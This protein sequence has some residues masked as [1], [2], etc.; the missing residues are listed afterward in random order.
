MCPIICSI[1]L[2]TN[3]VNRALTH[4]CSQ[5]SRWI[6]YQFKLGWGVIR[7]RSCNRRSWIIYKRT[8]LARRQTLRT[9]KL[10]KRDPTSHQLWGHRTTQLTLKE[11]NS[12]FLQTFTLASQTQS[13]SLTLKAYPMIRC[14]RTCFKRLVVFAFN[15]KA[16]CL[17]NRGG[18][19]SRSQCT[20]ERLIFCNVIY[21]KLRSSTPF[22]LEAEISNHRILASR[23][24]V[25]NRFT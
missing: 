15:L 8:T 1:S 18:L 5:P 25:P 11:W 13:T 14:I 6:T 22:H 16:I 24:R 19:T 3:L 21:L 9:R 7:S 4:W 20:Q 23:I 17:A 2:I 10:D 12:E